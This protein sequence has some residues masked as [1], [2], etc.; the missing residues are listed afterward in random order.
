MDYGLL[1]TLLTGGFFVGMWK[2]G[3]W[4][5]HHKIQDLENIKEQLLLSQDNHQELIDKIDNKID[6]IN[7]YNNLSIFDYDKFRKF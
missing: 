4:S 2:L 7:H 3:R 6:E 5:V 1:G